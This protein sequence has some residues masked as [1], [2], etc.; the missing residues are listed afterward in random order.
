MKITIGNLRKII[1]EV[2]ESPESVTFGVLYHGTSRSRANEIRKTGFSMDKIGEKLGDPLPGISTT[3]DSDIAE[4]HAEIA[5]EKYDDEPE[6][7]KVV[8]SKLKIAPGSLYFKLWNELGSSDASLQSLK[9]SGEWDGV[10]LFD[11]ETGDGIE[12]Q[13]VLLFEPTRLTVV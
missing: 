2:M 7:I 13:E 12:E 3:V 1:R 6:V 11:P 8:A 5:A 4:E 9:K 10:C